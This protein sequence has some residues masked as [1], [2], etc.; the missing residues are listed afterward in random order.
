MQRIATIC[1]TIALLCILG[2]TGI[3][4]RAE[5]PVTVSQK[6]RAFVPRTIEIALGQPLTIHNDDEYMHDVLVQAGDFQFDS[7]EQQI[8]QDVVIKFP[9]TGVY[10]VL[11]AIHPKMRLDVAVK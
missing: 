10:E 9:H 1:G 2:A 3:A 4:V 8:G 6:G 5:G 11:C 7:G